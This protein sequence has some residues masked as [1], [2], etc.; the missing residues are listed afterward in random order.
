MDL[1]VNEVFVNN[2]WKLNILFTYLPD[3]LKS[4]IK[5]NYIYL[6]PGVQD[7]FI[8]GN[9]PNGNYTTKAGYHWLL[10]QRLTISR[11]QSWKWLWKMPAQE[12][13]RLFFWLAFHNSIPTMDTLHHRGIVPTATC[14]VC[15]GENE[16]LMHC[17]RDCPGAKRIWD[18]L[19]F[20][21]NSFFQEHDVL[22]WLKQGATGPNDKMFIACVWWVWKA[23]NSMCFS[24][25]VTPFHRL[26]LSILNLAATFKA[27]FSN[28]K[29]DIAET[30]LISWLQQD[31]EGVIINVD[32]SS[33]GN[34]G[35]AGF[36]G[37][38]RNPD[39]VWLFGFSGNIGHAEVLK[40]ELS[41]W[42]SSWVKI[43]LGERVQKHHLL[44][45]FFECCEANQGTT[46]S[47]SHLWS[48]YSRD[49]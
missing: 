2:E 48:Y 5:G 25:E 6:N 40:A 17:L 19:D 16:T 47:L 30:R 7:L 29:K 26:L 33:L 42:Y 49:S 34:P 24:N 4:F 43:G 38:A 31:R 18:R 46:C 14:K 32:G 3:H 9:S 37:L 28:D 8:W 27:C 21:G 22:I 39:G 35:P 44:H 15:S 10:N 23:R 20:G 13:I 1:K 12:N 11:E 45:G 41:A 36:G